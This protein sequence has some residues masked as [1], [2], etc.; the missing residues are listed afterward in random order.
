VVLSEAY[1]KS[2]SGQRET[3]RTER[4][5]RKCGYNLQGLPA[6]S[7]C[8]ECGTPFSLDVQGR[9]CDNLTDAPLEYLRTLRHG[10]LL[11][12]GSILLLIF[13][14]GVSIF[15][16]W[17][18]L[19]LTGMVAG[20]LWMSGVWVVTIARPAETSFVPDALLDSSR[21]RLFCRA[22]Q[23][24]TMSGGI[25]LLT[26]WMASQ[27]SSASVVLVNAMLVM[28][29]A[30]LLV[31]TLFLIPFCVYLSALSDWAGA[32]TLGA[33]FRVVSLI[34]AGVAIVTLGSGLAAAVS[35][36][37]RGLT[38]IVALW[39]G[40][41]FILVWMYLLILLLTLANAARWAVINALGAIDSRT[42]IEKRKRE[43]SQIMVDR[44]MN[45]Q[46]TPEGHGGSWADTGF[47]ALADDD[48]S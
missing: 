46:P 19:F 22:G 33:R 36:N 37:I 40:I 48:E 28:S 47:I 42:R 15:A 27:S 1:L 32:D 29:A 5:C 18:V 21:L 34:L 39:S 38:S 12:A 3:I 8:P 20:V 2:I 25:F 11:L 23:L 4:A 16:G 13:G 26:A 7:V 6:G 9:F 31:S 43:Q 35:T 14:L 45:A 10:L 24:A 17:D 41:V 44:Q 30:A